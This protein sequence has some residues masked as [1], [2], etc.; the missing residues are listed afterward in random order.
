[1][2]ARIKGVDNSP[3]SGACL[4]NIGKG[5]LNMNFVIPNAL[6]N[7]L[8]ANVIKGTKETALL[9]SPSRLAGVNPW[10]ANM[11]AKLTWI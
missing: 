4:G 7:I 1:M 2:N 6:Q 10:V 8:V 5:P 9:K 3:L 11:I